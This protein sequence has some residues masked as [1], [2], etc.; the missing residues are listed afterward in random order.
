[1]VQFR[2]YELGLADFAIQMFNAGGGS[3]RHLLISDNTTITLSL[4]VNMSTISMS[5]D[6]LYEYVS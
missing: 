2:D 4:Q 5:Q 3:A 1:M 6:R